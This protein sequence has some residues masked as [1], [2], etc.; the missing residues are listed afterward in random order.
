MPSCTMFYI[1]FLSLMC[2]ANLFVILAEAAVATAAAVATETAA[3]QK[4]PEATI[5][6]H[7]TTDPLTI[8]TTMDGQSAKAIVD[9]TLNRALRGSASKSEQRDL[10]TKEAKTRDDEDKHEN[11]S[12]TSAVPE[13]ALS[14]ENAAS[15]LILVPEEKLE[16]RDTE[17]SESADTIPEDWKAQSLL[18]LEDVKQMKINYEHDSV[19]LKGLIEIEDCLSTESYNGHYNPKCHR[20]KR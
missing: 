9:S 2:L 8:T 17:I 3:S 11:E 12:V 4:D 6:A 19:K 5:L 18:E 20:T 1:T 10:E 16:E 15:A 13:T 14:D 7:D